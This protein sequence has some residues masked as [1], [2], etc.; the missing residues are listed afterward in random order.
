[1]DVI[2]A[3]KERR[4]INFFETGKSISDDKLR[5]L[6]EIANLSPS[7]FNLQPWKVIAVRDPERKKVLRQCAFNQPKV[8]EAS[9][10]LIMIADPKGVE[11]NLERV[12]DSWQELGYIKPEVR[13]TY[14]EMAKNLYSTEDSL[15]RKIFAVKNTALFAM[16]LMITAKGLGFETH[17]M[18]G[19]DEEC[20]KREFNIPADKIIPMLVAVGNLR[21]GITLLPRAFRRKIEEFVRFEQ[22]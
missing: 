5:E 21:S 18:D 6:I 17:P 13:Q 10:V 2:Q 14:T 19:F 22:Y 16:N 8:E 4:S 11:E 20:V 12:L 3:I 7:S 1:M 15:K 9:A